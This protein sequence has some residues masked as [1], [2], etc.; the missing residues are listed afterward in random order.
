MQVEH[1][2]VLP[3]QGCIGFFLFCLQLR[4]ET[5]L[6]IS[7]SA[8]LPFQVTYMA[9]PVSFLLGSILFI[10]T[11]RFFELVDF[12]I[13]FIVYSLISGFHCLLSLLHHSLIILQLLS[14]MHIIV[15][16]LLVCLLYYC[17]SL[18]TLLVICIEL[19]NHFSSFF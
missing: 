16:E 10:L 19:L 13:E 2:H 5:C 15:F 7:Q 1:F 12:K 6:N 3:A 11:E 14:T 8:D 17:C 9:L 4:L 18:K